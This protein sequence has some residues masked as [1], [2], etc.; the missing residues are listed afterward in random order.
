MVLEPLGFGEWE[1][2]GALWTGFIAK[3]VVVS[4]MAQL[5]SVDLTE[6]EIVESSF[7]KDLREIGSSFLNASVDTLKAIPGVIGI[8]FFDLTDESSTDLQEAI[9]TSFE[10]SSGGHGQ[11][12][13]LA[14]MVFVLLY[15]PCVA[16]VAAFRQ[17]FGAKWALVSVFGQFAI[18]WLFAFLVFQGGLLLGLG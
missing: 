10:E 7:G 5:Y 18:A 4:T 15:T 14:F 3:E 13:A 17:E 2:S 8:D 9:R 12:A 6:E 16:S 1:Q 11:L